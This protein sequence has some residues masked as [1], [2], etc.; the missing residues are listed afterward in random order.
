M[1]V[2]TIMLHVSRCLATAS[3]TASSHHLAEALGSMPNL[4]HLFLA[5]GGLNEEFYSTLRAN[6]S[7]IQ[8]CVCPNVNGD[9]KVIERKKEH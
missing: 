4:T 3:S 5:G 8:V 6:A 7:S 2:K 9:K 1:Q